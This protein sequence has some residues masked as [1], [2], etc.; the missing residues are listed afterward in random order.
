MMYV[1]VA[2]CSLSNRRP[3]LEGVRSTYSMYVTSDIFQQSRNASCD[4][5]LVRHRSNRR[6]SY[7]DQFRGWLMDSKEGKSECSLWP[8][9]RNSPYQGSEASRNKIV[10]ANARKAPEPLIELRAATWK[11]LLPSL[12]SKVQSCCRTIFIR[13]TGERDC[14]LLK[15][16]PLN[17]I[18][19]LLS[20]HRTCV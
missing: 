18:L 6:I 7:D 16:C 8:Q 2:S 20:F 19:N 1:N 5:I 15:S 13:G 3:G 17:F 12:Y 9:K 14:K 4:T 10:N 11:H